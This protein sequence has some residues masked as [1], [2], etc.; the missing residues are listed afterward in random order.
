MKILRSILIILAFLFIVLQ[1]I[2]FLY[3]RV[4]IP[5][6]RIENKIA[7]LVGRNLFLL[8]VLK[9]QITTERVVIEKFSGGRIDYR[10]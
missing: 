5:H 10:K 7:Y 1:V 4:T 3:G 9:N 6:T 8:V 2:S